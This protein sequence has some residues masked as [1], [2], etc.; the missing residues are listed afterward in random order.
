MPKPNSPMTPVH[1]I[2]QGPALR[3]WDLGKKKLIVIF[4]LG[5]KFYTHIM[6]SSY[7]FV[8]I[9]NGLV[10]EISSVIWIIFAG[11]IPSGFIIFSYSTKGH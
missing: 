9:I 7:L 3:S 2:L 4:Q 6:V 11:I 5:M 10:A 8:G 1:E